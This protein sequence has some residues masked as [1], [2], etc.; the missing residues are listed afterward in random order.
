MDEE[1]NYELIEQYEKQCRKDKDFPTKVF[2]SDMALTDTRIIMQLPTSFFMYVNDKVYDYIN[3]NV[4]QK[5]CQ[6]GYLKVFF[7]YQ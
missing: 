4:L 7:T 6:E 1:I 3:F 5:V 2:I